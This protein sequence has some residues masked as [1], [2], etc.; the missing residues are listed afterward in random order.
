MGLRF[1]PFGK[2]P[3]GA[4]FCQGLGMSIDQRPALNHIAIWTLPGGPQLPCDL[5]RPV[6]CSTLWT[7]LS[8]KASFSLAP[9]L[10]LLW[11]WLTQEGS[12]SEVPP[13]P[14]HTPRSAVGARLAS[15]MGLISLCSSLQ[16]GTLGRW[17]ACFISHRSLAL[18]YL[19]AFAHA[20][21]SNSLSP[22]SCD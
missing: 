2:T 3:R 1:H 21:P 11:A 20:V 13:E 6:I 18:P 5:P 9:R 22:T 15:L 10:L 17:C 16:P 19:R 4:F 7:Y 8:P 14:L 12:P